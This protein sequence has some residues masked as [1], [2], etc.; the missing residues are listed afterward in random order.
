MP[1]TTG[2]SGAGVVFLELRNPQTANAHAGSKFIIDYLASTRYIGCRNVIKNL[3]HGRQSDHC[4][5]GSSTETRPESIYKRYSWAGSGAQGRAT[6]S[7]CS[8]WLD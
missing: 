5:L 4:Y 8:I 1:S 7:G 3:W 2:S 6:P